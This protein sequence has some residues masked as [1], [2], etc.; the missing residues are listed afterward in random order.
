MLLRTRALVSRICSLTLLLGLG[1]CASSRIQSVSGGLLGE[2]SSITVSADG[3]PTWRID[4]RDGNLRI[5]YGN[6][7]L[8]ARQA[9]IDG[10]VRYQSEEGDL[11]GPQFE[12]ELAGG[13]RLRW[14]R[15]AFSMGGE[16][17][18]LQEGKTLVIDPGGE[19]GIV[20]GLWTSWR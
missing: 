10:V 16:D 13:R 11:A 17:R 14:Q 19:V 3:A 4:L 12:F 20:E 7:G 15:N 6:Q 1:G 18:T 5:A 9:A 8:V 2:G